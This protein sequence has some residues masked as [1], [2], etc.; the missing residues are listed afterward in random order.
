M[1]ASS[2]NRVQG[3]C[4]SGQS[5][6]LCVRTTG[7]R[8]PQI[9]DDLV[10]GATALV[11]PTIER[12]TSRLHVVDASVAAVRLAARNAVSGVAPSVWPHHFGFLDA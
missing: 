7:S 1:D 3:A 6:Q 4:W 8:Q 2:P 5:R 11:F 10:V 12:S 9:V